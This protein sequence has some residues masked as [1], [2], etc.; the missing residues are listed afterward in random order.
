MLL[1][2]T[3]DRNGLQQDFRALINGEALAVKVINI[4]GAGAVNSAV[5][6]GDNGNPH[7]LRVDF[8]WLKA[9]GLGL[10]RYGRQQL[11][12]SLVAPDVPGHLDFRETSLITINYTV[13]GRREVS[14]GVLSDELHNNERDVPLPLGSYRDTCA[15][16]Q[17]TLAPGDAICFMGG[18]VTHEFVS[19]EPSLAVVQAF[20]V[21]DETATLKN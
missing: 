19:V 21:V 20:A 7:G 8:P 6:E 1:R 5:E 11:G 10:K 14:F 17:A 9:T 18:L 13:K 16:E 15:I 2:Y 12:G 3:T 4:P